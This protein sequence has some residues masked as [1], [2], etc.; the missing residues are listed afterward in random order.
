MYTMIFMVQPQVYIQ[1]KDKENFPLLLKKIMTLKLSNPKVSIT[2][3]KKLPL[4]WLKSLSMY[5]F[6]T[7]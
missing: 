6:L 3:K 5:I 4:F 1:G 2:H 7:I